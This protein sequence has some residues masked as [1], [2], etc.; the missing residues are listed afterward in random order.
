MSTTTWIRLTGIDSARDQQVILQYLG[1]VAPTFAQITGSGGMGGNVIQQQPG[2][3][4][5][6]G[7]S[8]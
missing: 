8:S 4:Y 3:M 6:A 2:L 5:G 1:Q 7:P